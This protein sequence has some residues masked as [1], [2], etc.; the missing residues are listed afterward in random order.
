MRLIGKADT[1]WRVD[2]GLDSE[3]RP[4]WRA[5]YKPPLTKMVGDLQWRILHDIVAVNGLISVNGSDNCFLF[6]YRR[7]QFIT[8][9]WIVTDCSFY[10]L[11]QRMFMMFVETFSMYLFILGFRYSQKWRVKCQLFH[12]G[13][14]QAKMAIYL[15]RRNKIEESLDCDVN[16]RLNIYFDFYNTTNNVEEFTSIWWFH[17]VLCSVVENVFFGT[18]L[19]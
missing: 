15:S 5:L 8:A 3:V 18:V 7:K 6:V 11:L 13:L 9:F 4:A 12:F 10:Q 17:N 16:T 1:L 19:S 14:G 2:L